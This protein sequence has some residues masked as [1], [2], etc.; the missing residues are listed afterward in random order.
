M[1]WVRAD[2]A[3]KEW[4]AL[5]SRSLYKRPVPQLVTEERAREAAAGTDLNEQWFADDIVG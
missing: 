4:R 5:D 3:D 1:P 2:G